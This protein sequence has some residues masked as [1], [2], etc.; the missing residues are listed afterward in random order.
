MYDCKCYLSDINVYL[1]DIYLCNMKITYFHRNIS[2]GHSIRRVSQSFISEIEKNEI[3]NNVYMPSSKADP[4]SVIKNMWFA[5]KHR[6]RD[7]INHITGQLKYLVFVLPRHNTIVTVHDVGWMEG[8]KRMN[9]FRVMWTKLISVYPLYFCSN[10]VCVSDFTKE[11]IV[12]LFS[13]IK[14]KTIVISNSLGDE[15][16]Y[17]GK[18]FNVKKPTILHL[19]NCDKNDRKNLFRTIEALSGLNVHLRIIGHLN[20]SALLFLK[21]KEIEFSNEF[22]LTDE[23]VLKEYQ[24]CDIVN[25]VSLFEGFGMPIIE[26]QALGR[27]VITSNI[28][29]MKEIAG[30]GAVIVDPYDICAIRDSY[31]RVINDYDFRNLVLEKGLINACK[32]RSYNIANKYIDLYRSL[33][34]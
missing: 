33:C 27:I 20:D 19:G 28:S 21:E 17:I 8:Y 4:L 12:S 10:I 5:Y 2:C 23:A 22:D 7:G 29:P 13:S 34:V 9:I 31:I 32:Y 26:A 30:D 14:K 15:Y 18:I 6:N 25:F 11:A 16:E 24:N 1:C 3:V